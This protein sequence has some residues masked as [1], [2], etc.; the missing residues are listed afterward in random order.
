MSWES[1]ETQKPCPCGNST[2]TVID[3]SDDWGRFE[4][5]WR[6]DCPICSKKYSLYTYDYYNSGLH[7]QSHKWVETEIYTKSMELKRKAEAAKKEA[8]RLAKERYLSVLEEIFR[9][10]SKKAIW[11]VLNENIKWYKSLGTFY[12]HTKNQ[13]KREY[14]GELFNHSDLLSVLKIAN[15]KDKNI[16]SLLTD[17]S[18]MESESNALLHG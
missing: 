7:A 15:A 5:N 17:S 9:K 6:M 12:K 10:S 16:E 8:V 18:D 3:R 4:T 11:Q 13:E 14:L 2:Y 1:T